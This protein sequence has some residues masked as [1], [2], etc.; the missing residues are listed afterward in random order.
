VLFLGLLASPVL[1]LAGLLA[2]GLIALARWR[3]RVRE[4]RS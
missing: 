4:G 1:V 2:V 3:R